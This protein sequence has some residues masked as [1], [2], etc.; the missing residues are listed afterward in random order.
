MFRSILVCLFCLLYALPAYS[1]NFSKEFGQNETNSTLGSLDRIKDRLYWEAS[2]QNETAVSLAHGRLTEQR[3]I[4]HLNIEEGLS[5]SL[6]LRLAGRF[7]YDSVFNLTSYYPQDV[8]SDEQF[9]LDLRAAYLDFSSDKLDLR[10]G[11]QQIVWGQAIGLFF[12]DIVNPKDLRKFILPDFNEI[13]IP[14]WAVDAQFYSSISN[15]ELVFIPWPSFDKLPE[16]GAEFDMGRAFRSAASLP[17]VS[18]KTTKPSHSLSNS[19]TGVRLSRLI[20]G[21]DLSIFYLHGFDYFPSFEIEQLD[22]GLRIHKV[23]KKL[24][25]Y[26]LTFSFE[27]RDI[28][29]RGEFVFHK[30]KYFQDLDPAA[31]KGLRKGDL[32]EYVLGVGYVFPHGINTNLQFMQYI[33]TDHKETMLT[34]RIS[35]YMS[36]WSRIDFMDDSLEFENFLVF[37]LKGADLM[38][39]PKITY[40][41]RNMRFSFGLD[42]FDG[43]SDGYF[44]Q[45]ADSDRVYFQLTFVF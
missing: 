42:I 30:G 29:F 24:D 10:V 23:Y 8:K 25:N 26:G 15:L 3:N 40:K 7:I 33:V 21:L 17:V 32:L 27:K 45:F 2:Y 43:H 12:A 18:R 35:S 22:Q 37:S 41:M 1:D 13:R 34:D 11:R 38:Y 6:S 5:S 14:V 31:E 9:D 20:G 16:E 36:L 39:R 28:V 4:F 19:V 44:G